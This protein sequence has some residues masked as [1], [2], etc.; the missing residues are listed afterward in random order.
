[1]YEDLARSQNPTRLEWFVI[2]A[3]IPSVLVTAALHWSAEAPATRHERIDWTICCPVIEPGPIVDVF[4]TLIRMPRPAYPEWMRRSEIEGRVVLRAL[5]STR[6]RVYP[7]SILVLQATHVQ[8]VV[9]AREALIAAL[10]RPGWFGGQR[11]DA[12]VTIGMDFKPLEVP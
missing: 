1:M 9:P 11:I 5:V 10:F 6:G 3:L 4:P 7:S 2:H 12:W 8:F